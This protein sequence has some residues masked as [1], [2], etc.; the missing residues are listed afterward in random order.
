MKFHLITVATHE[1][2]YF[3][4]LKQTCANNGVELEILGWGKPWKGFTYRIDLLKE[5]AKSL[6][7]DD[8]VMFIDAFD[9]IVLRHQDEIVK[10]F[11]DFEKATGKHK[12]WMSYEHTHHDPLIR[13][14]KNKIFPDINLNAGTY[15]GRVED[16]QPMWDRT[17][18]VSE[19]IKSKDDQTCLSYMYKNDPDKGNIVLDETNTLAHVLLA[20]SAILPFLPSQKTFS[21]DQDKKLTVNGSSPIILHAPGNLNINS[22]LKKLEIVPSRDSLQTT[23]HYLRYCTLTSWLLKSKLVMKSLQKGKHLPKIF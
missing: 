7:S 8:I 13:Y 16:L 20:K 21:I 2:G 5:F 18:A 11:L 4:N 23:L 12:I 9:T 1:Q 15:M 3:E 6:P 10:E 19:Q 14:L 22:I 17:L